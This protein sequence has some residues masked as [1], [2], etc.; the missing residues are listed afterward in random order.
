MHGVRNRLCASL[1]D[2]GPPTSNPTA[3]RCKAP[4]DAPASIPHHFYDVRQQL[5]EDVGRGIIEY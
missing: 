4:F 1:I 2:R 3:L 5:E